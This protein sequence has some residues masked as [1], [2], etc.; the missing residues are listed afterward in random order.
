MYIIIN[1]NPDKPVMMSRKLFK[2]MDF[3]KGKAPWFIQLSL[4]KGTCSFAIIKRENKDTFL[5][6]CSMVTPTGN[7]RTPAMFCWTIPSLEYFKGVTGTDILS[8][9]V[10]KVKEV[11]TEHLTYYQICNKS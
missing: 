2:A 3:P 7:K 11:K 8:S 10:L 9:V 6:Q 4:I 1:A 5:T